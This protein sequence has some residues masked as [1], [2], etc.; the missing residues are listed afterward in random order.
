[1]LGQSLR[2]D[3][4][5]ASSW[6][7]GIE[8]AVREYRLHKRELHKKKW[9]SFEWSKVNVGPES[10]DERTRKSLGVTGLS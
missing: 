6:T 9:I 10:S 8:T 1:M 4:D 3:V 5:D 2:Q 7:V